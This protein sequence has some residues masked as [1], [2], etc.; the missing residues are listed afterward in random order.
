MLFDVGGPIDTEVV[1]E[2]L[3]DR[4]IRA[5]LAAEGME[6]TAD[7]VLR[8][9]DQAVA[10]FAPDA[11]RCMVWTLA[12][13]DEGT[14]RRAYARFAG[15]A[16]RTARSVE[17]GG[18]ELRPGIG[19]VL[20]RLRQPGLLLGLAAN[21]PAGVVAEL[22]RAEL[23]DLFSHKR[24]SGHHGYRKPDVR[25]F[26]SACEELEVSPEECVMVGD[27]IDNDI[28]PAR[29]LG[30]ATVRIRTGRHRTQQPR[31]WDEQPDADVLDAEGILAAVEQLARM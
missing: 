22:D 2:R 24:V 16:M 25:V 7:E 19:S 4:D 15:D 6:P 13:Q 27:K 10:C 5:A 1:P 11:Y 17:R 31:T 20:R 12:G 18:L 29:T 30:M 21:Q 8:A 28:V 3:I 9:S 23:A 14:A 26:L